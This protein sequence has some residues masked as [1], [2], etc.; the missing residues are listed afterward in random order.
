MSTEFFELGIPKRDDDMSNENLVLKTW[1][2]QS[3]SG[4]GNLVQVT[5]GLAIPKRVIH[6]RI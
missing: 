4:S 2:L 6:Y 1:Y 3:G 5:F